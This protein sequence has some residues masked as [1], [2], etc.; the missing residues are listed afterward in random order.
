[1]KRFKALAVVGLL[2]CSLALSGCTFDGDQTTVT[3]QEK[4]ADEWTSIY[5]SGYDDIYKFCD[6][7]TL[8]YL[9]KGSRKGGLAVIPDSP[10][11]A[12]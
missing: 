9:Y 5:S 2:G 12:R 8:V 6:G 10:E 7:K 1:M 11:C 4:R 3:E